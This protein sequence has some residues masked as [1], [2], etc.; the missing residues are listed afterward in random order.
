[1]IEAGQ[2]SIADNA[3]RSTD[4][5]CGKLGIKGK[6]FFRA[7]ASGVAGVNTFRFFTI[8]CCAL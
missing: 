2:S 1:M 7:R 6:M 8:G 5:F 3:R 4:W